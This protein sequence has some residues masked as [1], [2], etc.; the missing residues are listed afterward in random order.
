GRARREV[1][2]RRPNWSAMGATSVNERRRRL[3]ASFFPTMPASSGY[4][5]TTAIGALAI[6]PPGNRRDT[7]SDT[8]LVVSGVMPL[9]ACGQTKLYA[10]ICSHE[11]EISTSFGGAL[12]LVEKLSPISAYMQ[13]ACWLLKLSSSPSSSPKRSL[14]ETSTTGAC[15]RMRKP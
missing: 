13:G 7:T 5:L 8:A 15:S 4:R 9:L 2:C 3:D 6:P 14:S 12:G 1:R 11:N 10:C